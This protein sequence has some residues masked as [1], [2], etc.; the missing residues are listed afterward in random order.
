[1]S[2]QPGGAGKL[3]DMDEQL[4]NQYQIY[5]TKCCH[6]LV[7]LRVKYLLLLDWWLVAVAMVTILRNNE[8]TRCLA[9]IIWVYLA[10]VSIGVQSSMPNGAEWQ[11]N[12]HLLVGMASHIHSTSQDVR[13]YGENELKTTQ[14]CAVL[15]NRFICDHCIQAYDTMTS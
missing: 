4:V 9:N 10:T 14:L 15:C 2:F 11:D 7:L 8:E 12:R 13:C 3:Q 1:M 5:I 6:L